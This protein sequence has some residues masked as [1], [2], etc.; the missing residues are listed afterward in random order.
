MFNYSFI[1]PHHNSPKLLQRCLDSI[2][3]R[4]DVEIIVVD[5]KSDKDFIPI[6]KRV[7]VRLILITKEESKGA[8]MARNKGIELAKGKWLLFADCDDFYAD[9]FLDELDQYR[10]SN[11]DIIFFDVH[12][13]YDINDKTEDT[14]PLSHPIRNFKSNPTDPRLASRL[15][16]SL[17]SPWYKMIRRDFVMHKGI[18]FHEV[19]VGNDGWFSHFAAIKSRQIDA[20]DKKLYY[21]VANPN[22]MTHKVKSYEVEKSRVFE[23]SVIKSLKKYDPYWY[24]DGSWHRG[25]NLWRRQ[26]GYIHAFKLILLKLFYSFFIKND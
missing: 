17:N 16:H 19:P 10:D 6:I 26:L 5:D 4:E 18:R 9:G 12:Y 22:S 13:K 8:G 2:P 21:W 7:D 1:I 23:H 14:S 24:Y 25:F 11:N 3:S 15:K 20:V